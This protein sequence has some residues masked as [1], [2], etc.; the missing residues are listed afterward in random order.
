VSFN[1][2]YNFFLKH[3]S[4]SE[5]FSEILSQMHTGLHVKQPLFLSE[6]NETW[7][8]ETGF[9]KILKYQVSWKS[10]QWKPSC[11]ML[12]DRWTD[13]QTWRRFKS[14]FAIFRMRLKKK[15]SP[16]RNKDNTG[17]FFYRQSKGRLLYRIQSPHPPRLSVTAATLRT[18]TRQ[19]HC[20]TD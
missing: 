8:F 3:F 17:S 9:R 10:F 14:L 6:F 2:L 15:T 5:E 13:R 1:F 4:F 16:A 20:A 19:T 12:T 18:V 11:F 7:I